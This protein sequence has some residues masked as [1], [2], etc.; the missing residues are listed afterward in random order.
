[1]AF[2]IAH[3]NWMLIFLTFWAMC[4]SL[5]VSYSRARAEGLG[6][7]CA[8]GLMQRPERILLIIFSC[9]VAG[10][11]SEQYYHIIITVG[12]GIVAVLSNFTAFQRMSHV[13]KQTLKSDVSK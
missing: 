9:I 7:D 11:V 4:G 3:D 5:M 13:K 6:V 12:I 1:M 8:V 2:F 10:I